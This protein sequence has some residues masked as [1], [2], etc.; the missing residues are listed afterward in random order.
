[1]ETN[2]QSR[3]KKYF[4]LFFLPG[5]L[6][7]A[8]AHAQQFTPTVKQF[9]AVNV[10]TLALIH[11][12][13][14]DGTGG[15]SKTDQ[16]IIIIKGRIVQLG[17]A[18][19]IT[20]PPS[21]KIIDCSGK[22]IIPGMV[23]MHEH[24]FYGE[25]LPPNYLGLAMPLSFPRLYLAGGATTIRT[26]GT[27]EPQTDLNIRK[28][29]D[30]GKMVGP[31]IDVTGPYI[32]REFLPIPEV[33]FIKSADEAEEDVSYWIKKGCTSFKV[34][35]DI[36]QDDLK[37]VVAVAHKNN[38]KVT[39]HLCSITYREA[40]T[41][42][43]DNLEHG[44]IPCSDF[45]TGRKED[46]C[47]FGAVTPSLKKL[48]VN[49]AEMKDLMKF[50]IEKKVAITST[51]PVFEPYTGREIIPGDG[52]AALAP[53]IKE[54][55]EQG[56]NAAVGKDSSDAALFKKEMAW[57]KQFVEMGGRLM[58]GVDPTG[59]GRTIPGYA[60]RHVL[61]LLKEAGFT[62]SQAVKICSLN[63]AEYLGRD[64]DIGTIA[65]GKRAD[66][67]LIGG[68]P[69][70]QIGDVRNTEIVFKNG[71]GFDSKKIF[72]SVNGKVGLY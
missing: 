46:V 47:A 57:E 24:L 36:T 35:M 5:F 67:V 25:S 41:I 37:K 56:Y 7:L 51:L 33:H 32:E 19:R 16:T 20:A 71:V 34:Y 15:L 59:A 13:V 29:I 44:F 22:T 58:A 69:E 38:L 61:E 40:A 28:W 4:L 14:V 52:S 2:F 6:V 11:A 17:N 48:D 8:T 42:G 30:E 64:K 60:D 26:T 54:V 62:F 72:E 10:D 50:L 55:V 12:K 9:I 45:V 65:I 39:G 53:Q 49:S 66:L 70:K 68:D 31:D 27:V 23:M 3:T 18:S 43:I 63:A 21:A 1:M